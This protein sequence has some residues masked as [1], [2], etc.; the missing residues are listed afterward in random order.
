LESWLILITMNVFPRSQ[1]Q[2]TDLVSRIWARG[3]DPEV[4]RC[5]NLPNQR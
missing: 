1:W 2:I 4:E 5:L 3:R